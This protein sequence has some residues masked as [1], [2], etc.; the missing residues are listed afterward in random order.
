MKHGARTAWWPTI[1]KSFMEKIMPK[2]VTNIEGKSSVHVMRIQLA[3]VLAKL[4]GDQQV[5]FVFKMAIE[6]YRGK[7]A[8][9]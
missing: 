6:D 2:L 7:D 3:Q 8:K 5:S 4:R 9:S 1:T